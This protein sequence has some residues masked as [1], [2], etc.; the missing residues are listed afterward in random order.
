MLAA[1]RNITLF[2]LRTDGQTRR[3]IYVPTNIS[4]VSIYEVDSSKYTARVNSAS[5]RSEEITCKI[6]IPVDAD[7]EAGRSYIPE[8]RY[9]ILTDDEAVSYWTLQ[10]GAYILA[11]DKIAAQDIGKRITREELDALLRE[12]KYAGPLIS[13]VEYADNTRRGSPR[14]RHWRIGGA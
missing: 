8:G 2:N 11:A 1:M 10:R 13:I 7:F 6:R 14:V 4:G 3:E 12:E 9:K 5:S